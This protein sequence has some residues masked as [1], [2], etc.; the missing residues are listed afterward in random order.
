M[1]NSYFECVINYYVELE[2]LKLKGGKKPEF[3]QFDITQY[4]EKLYKFR[5]GKQ[6]DY[7][8]LIND[9]VWLDAPISFLDPEDARINLGQDDDP[10]TAQKNRT[11]LIEAI[12]GYLWN[13]AKSVFEKCH[14]SRNEFVSLVEKNTDENQ[15]EDKIIKQL[16]V[17]VS[18]LPVRDRKPTA[19]KISKIIASFHDLDERV[20]AERTKIISS[21]QNETKVCCFSESYDNR[22]MWENYAGGYAG[23]IIEYTRPKAEKM[24]VSDI[25]TILSF[26]PVSYFDNPPHVDISQLFVDM[27]SNGGKF[28]PTSESK[29]AFA[30]LYKQIVTKR[31]NYREEREWRLIRGKLESNKYSF[32]FVSAVYAGYKIKPH[33]LARL[34]NICKNKGI[35]LYIQKLDPSEKRITYAEC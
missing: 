29:K 2:L 31:I 35:H 1:T 9:Y 23:F 27:A 28:L 16:T 26:L 5:S 11:E 24:T 30:G 12:I 32:P 4:P 3:T 6:H 17:Y 7:E 15:S 19:E 22:F 18:T 34:K 13:S 25:S 20:E 33:N 10:E 8:A 21:F 14:I